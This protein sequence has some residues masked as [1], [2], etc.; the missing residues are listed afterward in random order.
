MTPLTRDVFDGATAERRLASYF[1]VSTSEAFGAL[2]T[3]A[4]RGF[5]PVWLENGTFTTT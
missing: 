3:T 2:T 1:G 5:D 4:G